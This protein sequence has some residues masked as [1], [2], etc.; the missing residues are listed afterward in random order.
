[1]TILQNSQLLSLQTLSV[2]LCYFLGLSVCVSLKW[3]NF[4]GSKEICFLWCSHSGNN[5]DGFLIVCFLDFAFWSS[6]LGLLLQLSKQFLWA[7]VLPDFKAGQV[8]AINAHGKIFME[9]LGCLAHL[10]SRVGE[11]H[12]LPASCMSTCMSQVVVLAL[13][14]GAHPG[15]CPLACLSHHHP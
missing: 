9:P 10:N 4:A 3:I 6:I 1:M 5:S 2:H 8:R 12:M 15:T 11:P 13:Q 7:T 14:R